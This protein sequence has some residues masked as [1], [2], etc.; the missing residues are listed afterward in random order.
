[1]VNS[2]LERLDMAMDFPQRAEW[3]LYLGCWA[4]Y[5]TI[6]SA[7]CTSKILQK[8]EVDFT[9]LGKNEKCCGMPFIETGEVEKAQKLALTNLN[10]ARER[11]A[12]KILTICPGCYHS[13]KQALPKF[14]SEEME[15]QH[16]SSFLSDRI[17][18]GELELTKP[19]E[20]KVTYHD[21]CK[22]ARYHNILEEPRSVIKSIKGV[23]FVE[24]IHS[25]LDA[26]CCGRVYEK[27]LSDLTIGMSKERVEEAA[28]VKAQV[29]A[30]SCPICARNLLIGAQSSKKNVAVY[31]LP[32]IVARQAGI[33]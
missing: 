17:I 10:A 12:T 33:I 5:R 25:G 13:L 26:R 24:L 31:D 20:A 6:E 22:L 11:G 28:S 32:V 21:P 18:S 16:V 9:V 3:I 7:W 15:V 2:T 29:M 1:L 8:L 23:Q 4:S 30:T 19:L 27:E 14:V